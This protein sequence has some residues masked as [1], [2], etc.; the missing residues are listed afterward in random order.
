VR[1]VFTGAFDFATWLR[2]VPQLPLALVASATLGLCLRRRRLGE[3]AVLGGALAFV[4]FHALILYPHQRFTLPSAMLWYLSLPILWE[5]WARG[6]E[7][8]AE[9]GQGALPD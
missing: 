8:V 4:L 9:A 6:R 7:G 5:T 2:G 3:A 1:A